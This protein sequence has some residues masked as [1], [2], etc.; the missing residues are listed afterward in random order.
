MCQ[1]LNKQGF[2][3]TCYVKTFKNRTKFFDV[4]PAFNEGKGDGD[5]E[6]G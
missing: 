3:W 1:Q 5:S 4:N 6:I 2:E